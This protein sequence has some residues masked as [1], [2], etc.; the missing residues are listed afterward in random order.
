MRKSLYTDSVCDFLYFVAAMSFQHNETKPESYCFK[1]VFEGPLKCLKVRNSTPLLI[2]LSVCLEK[3]IFWEEF[4]QAKCQT[5]FLYYFF[6]CC[7]FLLLW[8]IGSLLC[9]YCVQHFVVSQQLRQI[10]GDCI[11]PLRNILE[12]LEQIQRTSE[13]CVRNCVKLHKIK[14]IGVRGNTLLYQY[15]AYVCTAGN[16][17]CF[18]FVDPEEANILMC[19]WSGKKVLWKRTATSKPLLS[20]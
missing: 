7:L 16:L 12:R 2:S 15:L 20:L 17:C 5:D 1:R 9:T 19:S 8:Y 10:V 18:I 13:C 6:G 11:L 4:S 3:C 14:Q